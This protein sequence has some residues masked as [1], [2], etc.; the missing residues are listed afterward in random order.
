MITPHH[1]IPELHHANTILPGISK[2][3]LLMSYLSQ[4]CQV[5]K[6][7]ETVE[8]NPIPPVF[9]NCTHV[10]TV[11]N[12]VAARDLYRSIISK[13]VTGLQDI[14]ETL[15]KCRDTNPWAF[16]SLVILAQKLLEMSD[17]EGALQASSRA[18]ELQL[19][20]GTL[21]VSS[22]DMKE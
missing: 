3:G 17:F 13:D 4:L 19:E 15:T 2:P 10:L 21:W 20:W 1:D 11:D 5:A 8:S 22:R 7:Y 9:D 18:L 16:E 12:D 6:T 14:V